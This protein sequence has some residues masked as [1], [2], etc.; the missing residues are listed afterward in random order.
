MN[1][2]FNDQD[3]NPNEHETFYQIENYTFQDLLR[4]IP[5]EGGDKKYAEVVFACCTG[6]AQRIQRFYDITND[7]DN[8]LTEKP[9]AL[10]TSDLMLDIAGRKSVFQMWYIN[11]TFYAVDHYDKNFICKS[12]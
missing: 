1:I 10:F 5:E 12:M 11:E 3:I 9:N 7:Y 2:I 6:S 4:T 8:I